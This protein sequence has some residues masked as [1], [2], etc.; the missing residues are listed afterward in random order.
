MFPKISENFFDVADVK[1]WR[2]LEE[3]GKWMRCEGARLDSDH[4]L[5]TGQV[6]ELIPKIDNGLE[7]NLKSGENGYSLLIK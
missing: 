6:K 7:L 2:C 5:T 1:Q 3:S 4:K